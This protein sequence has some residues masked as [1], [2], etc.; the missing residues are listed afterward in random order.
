MSER[1]LP[2]QNTTATRAKR[3]NAVAPSAVFPPSANAANTS[4][5]RPR[6]YSGVHHL[7]RHEMLI[8]GVRRT[9]P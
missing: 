2:N 5:P 4:A 3:T 9:P 7:L 6:L 8:A 1:G